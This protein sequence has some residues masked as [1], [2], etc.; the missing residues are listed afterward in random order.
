MPNHLSNH[1]SNGL[2]MVLSLKKKV[3]CYT[4]RLNYLNEISQRISKDIEQCCD[5]LIH[6]FKDEKTRKDVI[7]TINSKKKDVLDSIKAVDGGILWV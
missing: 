6:H 2:N 1:L 4:K 5:E 3:K 7:K